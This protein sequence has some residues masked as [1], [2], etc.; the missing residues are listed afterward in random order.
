MNNWWV[1]QPT[2]DA[3]WLIGY[4]HLFKAEVHV[5]YFLY[6]SVL[7]LHLIRLGHDHEAQETHKLFT[8]GSIWQVR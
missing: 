4:P 7:M 1:F 3:F 5:F 6:S 2:H 8:F